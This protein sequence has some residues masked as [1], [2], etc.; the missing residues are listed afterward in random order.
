VK[1]VTSDCTT[2]LRSQSV[3][4]LQSWS[5][6]ILIYNEEVGKHARTRLITCF[7]SRAIFTTNLNGETYVHR[8]NQFVC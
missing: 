3:C 6:N 7:A 5:M 8:L 4:I 1:F 2:E